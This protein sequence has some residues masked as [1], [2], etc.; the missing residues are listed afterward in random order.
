MSPQ[1]T[2]LLDQST[3]GRVSFIL[4][5]LGLILILVSCSPTPS[6]GTPS[7]TVSPVVTSIPTATPT[8]MPCMI[9]HLPATPQ[10]L[11]AEF[12][13]RGHIFGPADA[14]V[15]IVV[16][17]D[18][19]CP[20]CAF[21]AAS[22]R[23]IRLTHTKD[24]RLIYVNT[25]QANR[26]KDLPATQAV[27]SADLQGKF[28]EM[29]D[30]LFEKQSEW[31]ALTSAAFETWVVKQAAGIGLDPAKFQ[32]DYE[33]KTVAQRAQQVVQASPNQPISP[34]ILFVNG[35]SP[36]AGL[37]DFA[38]LDTVVRMEALSA[39]QSSSCPPWVINPLKQYIATLHTSKGDVV[40]QL[41]PDKA[42]LAV[43]NFVSL[44]RS[45]WYDGIT[46]YKMIP[47][48]LVMTGDPSETGMGNAGYLFKTEIPPGLSFD[49]AGLVA[50]DNS[51]PDTN[52]SRFFITLAPNS[53]LEGQYTVFGQVLSGINTLSGLSPRD[54]KPGMVL[55]QGD[56]LISIS[57]EEK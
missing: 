1:V 21:L 4:N 27:E 34:P 33:G 56:E 28:W 17:S 13:S 12:S 16:F 3:L 39:R 53:Q 26:D 5:L 11:G 10:A 7:L 48:F 9:L 55:P 25:P 49:N 20:A 51:G 30:L 41:F 43:N 57:I 31:A 40:L 23:Q 50:M 24:V 46:F 19:Q 45:G 14:P 35:T 32:A 2:K 8:A 47:N 22:L 38:S 52:G 54:P 29:H 42:P 44:A 18:Y 36:Y 37:A 15:T 6:L